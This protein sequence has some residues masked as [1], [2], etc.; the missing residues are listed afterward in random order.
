MEHHKFRKKA[1]RIRK[2]GSEMMIEPY[3]QEENITI[4]NGDCLEILPQLSIKGDVDLVLTDPPYGMTGLK[5]DKSIDLSLL[6]KELKL[7]GKDNTT[8]VFTSS[9]PFTTDLI[10]SNRK[11]FK[12]EWIWDKFVGTNF[13]LAKKMPLKVHENICIFYKE[14]SIYNPQ[15]T[16]RLCKQSIRKYKI[17]SSYKNKQTKDT[18]YSLFTKVFHFEGYYKFPTSILRF[19]RPGQGGNQFKLLQ[20][21]PAEK[22]LGLMNYLVLTYTNLNAL[23]LDPFMGSGT[24][25][26]ASKELNRRAVGIEL[27]KKYCDMAIKRI[28]EVPDKLFK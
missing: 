16:E 20:Y 1:G 17:G 7:L 12:Y 23:I 24:T 19:K 6:W 15:K 11:W 5:W 28:K 26:V 22:P 21:H 8:Y 25:L 9:Q 27:E 2:V 14:K 10:N 18:R 13:L 3:Y 4:Y